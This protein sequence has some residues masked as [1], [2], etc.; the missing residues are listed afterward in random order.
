MTEL[1]LFHHVLG[2]TDGVRNFAELIRAQGHTVHTPDL[3][4][5]RTFPT[6]DEG[7]GYAGSIGF[8]E[9]MRRGIEAAA[10]LPKRVVFGGFSVGV[11]PAQQ[12]LQTTPEALGGLFL[13][14]FIDP[15]QLEGSWPSGVPAQVHGMDEDPFFIGDGDLEAARAVQADHPE[16]EAFLY[17]GKT[18]LFTDSSSADYDQAAAVT[19]LERASEFLSSLA[20]AQP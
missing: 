18:H 1:V 9:V 8:D 12:L 19:V 11:M 5:G 7:I 4:E 16:L 10:P 13:H 14:A 2:L 17:P 20:P 15:T 3:F 6:I